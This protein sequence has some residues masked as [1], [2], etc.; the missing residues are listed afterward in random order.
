MHGYILYTGKIEKG[1]REA[2]KEEPKWTKGKE[3]QQRAQ[4]PLEPPKESSSSEEEEP[5]TQ[6]RAPPSDPLLGPR[7]SMSGMSTKFCSFC[8]ISFISLT[9]V[10]F[11]YF[12]CLHC[13]NIHIHLP[14]FSPLMTLETSHKAQDKTR[15][16]INSTLSVEKDTHQDTTT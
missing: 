6:K 14:S 1:G 3:H 8:P 15:Q 2:N 4:T 7:W 13:A 5:P 10:L 16:Y 11:S 12:V 9:Y